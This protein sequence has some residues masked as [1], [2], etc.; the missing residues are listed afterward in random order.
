MSAIIIRKQ[1]SCW[2]DRGL[3]ENKS[4]LRLRRDSRSHMCTRMIDSLRLIQ[5]T[6]DQWQCDQVEPNAVGVNEE[7]K[8][9]FMTETVW[10]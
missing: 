1:F 6:R 3:G 4:K 2:R 8:S 9:L 7:T 5:A 10:D